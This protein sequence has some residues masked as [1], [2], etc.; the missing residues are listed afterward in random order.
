MKLFKFVDI[1]TKIQSFLLKKKKQLNTLLIFIKEKM[2]KFNQMLGMDMELLSQLKA[3][4][5]VKQSVFVL[6]LTLFQSLKKQVFHSHL[7]TK[8]SAICVVMMVT[9]LI[10][11]Y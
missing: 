6:I 7:K 4:N 10:C 9:R 3:E 5:L 11:L 1:Y 2:L 8:V